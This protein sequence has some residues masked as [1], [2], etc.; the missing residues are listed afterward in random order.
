MLAQRTETPLYCEAA[1]AAAIPIIRHL[2]HRADEID[3]LWGIVN[4]T[5]NFVMTR[6]EQGDLT[7]DDA[8]A[9]A[10]R[11]GFAEA[12]PSADIDGHDAAA[13]LS[14]LAYRAFGAWVRPDGFL[15][16]GIREIDPADCD[17]AESMGFRIRQIARAVR[18]NGALDMAVEPLLLPSWHLLASVEEEYNAVYL[19][20][21]SSG[22]LSLFGKGAGALPTATAML[23]DLIDLAQDN[24][25]RWP[26]PR[27]LAGRSRRL[28][29]RAGAAPS[30]PAHHRTAASRARAQ[31]SKAWSAGSASSSRTARLARRSGIAC[32][33]AFMIS[34]STDTQIAEVTAAVGRLAASSSGCASE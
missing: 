30:L 31:S 10:Q 6:L 29:G 11:L 12:D 14:I 24:S 9:E 28:G 7:L 27:A 16:R 2:S 17:L 18:I 22:D 3:S 20:C 15:V 13:K 4:A 25:V 1:A 26:V 8:I 32:D 23:G 33:I 34:P 19:R 21:V 5:C